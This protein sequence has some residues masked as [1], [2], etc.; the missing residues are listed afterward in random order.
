MFNL[1]TIIILISFILG[2]LGRWSLPL[3][4]LTFQLNDLVVGLLVVGGVLTWVIERWKFNWPPLT[5]SI[6]AFIAIAIFSLLVNFGRFRTDE[7]LVGSFYL[8]RWIAYAG[9][10]F[11][12]FNILKREKNPSG[13]IRKFTNLVTVTGV[14]MAFI[15]LLQYAFYPNLRNLFYLGWDPHYFR[16]F[17]TL[18]DPNFM[19]IILVFTF[20]LIFAK[21]L[22]K[23]FLFKKHQRLIFALLIVFVA[24]V[25]TFSRSSYIA[26]AVGILTIA[27]LKKNSKILF[28]FASLT[29]IL[30]LVFFLRVIFYSPTIAQ[31]TA[32]T[33]AR[34]VSWERS[35]IIIKG[36][37]IFGIGFNTYRFERERLGFKSDEFWPTDHAGA[38]TD[39]SLLFVWATTGIFG[40]AA[41]LW[42]WWKII[43]SVTRRQS[44]VV[45]IVI[46]AS[47][48]ALFIHSFFV[49]SL[50]YP[51]VM[52]WM[53]ILAGISS[54][55]DYT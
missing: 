52:E 46:L 23:P 11:L 40:L 10:Y 28:V 8:L 3:P 27:F 48:S 26:L 34:F 43:K 50:F 16:L 51:W 41:Y 9:L 38:G 21:L 20:L 29:G 53:W 18:L 45:S 39:S 15:G 54:F 6:F 36:H 31:R 5:K 2:H 25:L 37:P 32:S 55:K 49:N 42:L 22:E 7:L 44:S 33:Q 13:Y 47:I 1:I 24:L 19:G 35:L 17:G 30:I 14:L 4:G 12:L